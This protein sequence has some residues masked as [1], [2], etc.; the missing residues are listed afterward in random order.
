MKFYTGTIKQFNS[1]SFNG[2]LQNILSTTQTHVK[3]LKTHF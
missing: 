3:N 1:E 2:D